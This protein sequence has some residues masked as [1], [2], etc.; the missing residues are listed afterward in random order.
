MNYIFKTATSFSAAERFIFKKGNQEIKCGFLY[1]NFSFSR[2]SSLRFLENYDE[3]IGFTL[4]KIEYSDKC[5]SNPKKLIFL[6]ESIPKKIQN[7]LKK[8]ID[9]HLENYYRLNVGKSVKSYYQF[10]S[11]LSKKAW[12]LEDHD[13]FIWGPLKIKVKSPNKE[14]IKLFN[15]VMSIINES[16]DEIIK[17]CGYTNDDNEINYINFYEDFCNAIDCQKID[18]DTQ[19]CYDIIQEKEIIKNPILSYDGL[20]ILGQNF[21]RVS[22]SVKNVDEIWTEKRWQKE[23]YEDCPFAGPFETG[24]PHSSSKGYYYGHM[25]LEDAFR[26]LC[27]DLAQSFRPAYEELCYENEGDSFNEYLKQYGEHPKELIEFI[28]RYEDSLNQ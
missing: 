16:R 14:S 8:Y 24:N 20:T 12:A 21:L 23:T 2:E 9:K 11:A 17:K 28:E 26:E 25:S 22:D 18:S 5:F 15:K 1:E 19:F 6:S 4:S 3:K 27:G 7:N 10:T 13:F